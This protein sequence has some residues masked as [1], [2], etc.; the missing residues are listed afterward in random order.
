MSISLETHSWVVT[1]K[2]TNKIIFETFNPRVVE[3][4][5]REKYEVTPIGEHLRNLNK[6]SR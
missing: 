4:I 2:G 5:N 6:K 1:E 3:N